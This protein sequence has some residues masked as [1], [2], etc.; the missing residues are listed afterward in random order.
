VCFASHLAVS[1]S[2][3]EFVFLP[4]TFKSNLLKKSQLAILMINIFYSFGQP[5]SHEYNPSFYKVTF[6]LTSHFSPALEKDYY[7]LITVLAPS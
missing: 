2:H 6:E 5:Y 1:G 7:Y 4:S 3:H